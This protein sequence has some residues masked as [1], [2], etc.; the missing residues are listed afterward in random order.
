MTGYRKIRKLC[1]G[2]KFRLEQVRPLIE[3]LKTEHLAATEAVTG[4]EALISTCSL[5]TRDATE[6]AIQLADTAKKFR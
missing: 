1:N 5:A 3:E 6:A 2:I 4:M